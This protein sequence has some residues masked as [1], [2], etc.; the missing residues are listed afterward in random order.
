MCHLNPQ[1]TIFSKRQEEMK[2]GVSEHYFWF[3]VFVLTIDYMW[4]RVLNMLLMSQHNADMV[5][6]LYWPVIQYKIRQSRYVRFMFHWA[7]C[8]INPINK[9]TFMRI[10]VATYIRLQ[11]DNKKILSICKVEKYNYSRL[12]DTELYNKLKK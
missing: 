7:C 2:A 9:I 10:C 6:H 4:S 5:N 1:L 12:I 8:F 11:K 3:S